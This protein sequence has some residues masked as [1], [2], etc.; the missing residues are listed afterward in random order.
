[1][2]FRYQKRVKLGKGFGLN[3]SKSGIR[4][5]YRSKSGSVSSKGYSVRTGIPGL[6]YKKS[7]SKGGCML[8]FVVG[9]FMLTTMTYISCTTDTEEDEWACG[10]Y[11]SKTLYTGPKG[12]CYY[13]TSNKNKTYVERSECN[14]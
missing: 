9:L 6:T 4:P 8:V 12:G 2:G 13:Y 14:C 1:M 11:N 10:T 3:V 5:S 7:F